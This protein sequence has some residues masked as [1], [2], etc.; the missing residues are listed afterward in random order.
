MGNFSGGGNDTA[1]RMRKRDARQ[2]SKQLNRQGHGRY[3]RGSTKGVD[4]ELDEALDGLTD[5]A[6]DALLA[7][8]HAPAGRIRADEVPEADLRALRRAYL[9]RT[10]EDPETGIRHREWCECAPQGTR[11]AKRL[12]ERID[13]AGAGAGAGAG[14]APDSDS[15]RHATPCRTTTTSI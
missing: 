12:L 14:A 11:G 2:R 6:R 10:W 1:E 15:P 9:L 7:C 3:I 13:R 4:Q 8:Y 5:A